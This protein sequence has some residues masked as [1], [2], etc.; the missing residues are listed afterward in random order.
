MLLF[1]MLEVD[2][3]NILRQLILYVTID[4]LEISNTHEINKTEQQ[5]DEFKQYDV[6]AR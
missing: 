1:N 2:V 4:K 6:M 5:T 3:L